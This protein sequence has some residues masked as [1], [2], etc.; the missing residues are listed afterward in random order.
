V[1]WLKRTFGSTIGTKLLV[2][3]SGL[4]LIGF[5]VMHMAGNLFIYADGGEGLN[6]YAEG[7]H[8]IPGF[9]V[10]EIGLIA[11]F[12]LHIALTIRLTMANKQAKGSGYAVSATKRKEGIMGLLASKTMALSG[13]IVLVFLVVHIMDFRLKREDGLELDQ[14]I[15]DTLSDP[16]HATL[17]IVGS[18]LVAWHVSHGL[19]SAF[20]SLGFNHP[21]LTPMLTK[22]G[23]ALAVLLG[24]GFASIPV[25][26][27]FFR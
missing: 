24:I 21:D 16:L 11:L 27:A 14:L 15:F 20:R 5:L 23:T 22:A 1:G 25:W 12:V 10:I 7:L 19:Q 8:N 6:A 13:I 17:Y 2:G 18:L 9:T 26:V 4:A 3:L